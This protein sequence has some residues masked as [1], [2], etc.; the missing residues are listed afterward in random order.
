METATI[1]IQYPFRVWGVSIVLGPVFVILYG[2]L[3][4]TSS[5]F[6]ILAFLGGTILAALFG[7]VYSIPAF[8]VYYFCFRILLKGIKSKMHLRLI[9]T[10]I[11]IFCMIVTFYFVLGQEFSYK[12]NADILLTYSIG[13]IIAGQL[14]RISKC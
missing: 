10:A 3:T 14:V 12:G 5:E 2:L 1:S 6:D 7:F 9:L 8:I 13:I 4:S 11:A